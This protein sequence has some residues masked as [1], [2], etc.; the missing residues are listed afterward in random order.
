MMERG[1]GDGRS[2]FVFV[3]VVVVV[4]V[5]ES[6]VLLLLL[7]L[8][9]TACCRRGSRSG[10]STRMSCREKIVMNILWLDLWYQVDCVLLNI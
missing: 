6:M 1:G 8:L 4:V 9:G 7:L 10:N 2:V 5:E 3:F